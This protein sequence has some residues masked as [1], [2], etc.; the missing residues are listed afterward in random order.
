MKWHHCQILKKYDLLS[1]DF[2]FF[3]KFSFI[4]TVFKCMPCSDKKYSSDGAKIRGAVSGNCGVRRFRT[5]VSQSSFSV[6][7]SHVW[8]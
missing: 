3:F 2:F 7:G 6:K 8:M 1:F 4:K 5:T